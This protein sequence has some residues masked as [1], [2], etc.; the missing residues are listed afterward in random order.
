MSQKGVTICECDSFF[1]ATDSFRVSSFYY[2]LIRFYFS[3]LKS[4]SSGAICV[5]FC[6]LQMLLRY[7]SLSI[8]E[9]KKPLSGVRTRP[10]LQHDH[11]VSLQQPLLRPDRRLWPWHRLGRKS[12]LVQFKSLLFVS[13]ISTWNCLFFHVGK[14]RSSFKIIEK[15]I[16]RIGNKG[17]CREWD[18]RIEIRSFVTPSS[19]WSGVLK[20]HDCTSRR[21]VVHARARTHSRTRWRT[22]TLLINVFFL[23]WFPL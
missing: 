9:R 15:K 17:R 2:V 23:S 22:R 12:L 4:Y 21:A 16:D 11:R 1:S 8:K 7:F 13:F 5:L 19:C 10:F 18:G 20:R 6:W 14:S 3:F